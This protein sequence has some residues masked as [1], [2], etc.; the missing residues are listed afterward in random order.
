MKRAL[1]YGCRR[2]FVRSR[3]C[4]VSA[5]VGLASILSVPAY[6][7]PVGNTDIIVVG[8]NVGETQSR[9]TVNAYVRGLG[10]LSSHR[11]LARWIDP[12]CP[13]VIGLTDPAIVARTRKRLA[14]IADEVGVPHAKTGCDTNLLLIFTDDGRDLTQR[15]S[16]R[17]SRSVTARSV[18]E[19]QALL[20]S[21]AP[22]RWWYNSEIRDRDGGRGIDAPMP[23][24]GGVEGGV[25]PVII[26]DGATS[27]SHYGS[28]L[29]SSQVVRALTS[30]TVVIDV[31][32]AHGQ[33]FDALIDY[34]ALVAVA[35]IAPS[36]TPPEH[37]VLG[38]FVADPAPAGLSHFDRRF[39]LALYALPLDRTIRFHRGYLTEALLERGAPLPTNQ[40][41]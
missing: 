32:R 35:E 11:P 21:E 38:L 29:V 10:V 31:T 9:A 14:A 18:T 26:P 19:R 13:R 1:V 24:T 16:R 15:I 5:A 20:D 40:S 12:I 27:I 34:A 30:A 8:P 37:S 33:K 7:Q 22:V 36:D 2:S 4:I 17:R 39:L 23:W 28:S 3:L 41:P 25:S 6:S